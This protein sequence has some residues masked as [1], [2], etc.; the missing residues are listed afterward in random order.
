MKWLFGLLLLA[1]LAFFAFMQWGLGGFGDSKILQPQPPLYAEKIK[2]LPAV[3]AS[4]S[5]VP[6]PVQAAAACMEWGDFSGN[7]LARVTEALSALKLG[8]NLTQRQIEHTIGYWVYLSPLNNSAEV[9]KEVAQIKKLGL[10]EYFVIQEEG[11]WQNAISLGVFK[12]A[13]AAHNFR[14]SIKAKG[15]ESAKVGERASKHLFTV[16]VLKDPGAEAMAK[17]TI[18]QKDYPDSE[19]KATACRQIGQSQLTSGG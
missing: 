10:N 16:F 15:L 5:S 17:I 11:K 9:A 1:S 13:E 7:D 4:A 3:I 19:L 6:P 18:M 14:D 8:N 2:L 12:T